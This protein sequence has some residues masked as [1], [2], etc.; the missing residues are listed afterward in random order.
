MRRAPVASVTGHSRSSRPDDVTPADIRQTVGELLRILMLRRWVFFVPFCLATTAAFVSSHYIPR[1]Y[2]ARTTFEQTNDPVSVELPPTLVTSSYT[3]FLTTLE[4]DIKSPEVMYPVLQALGLFDSVPA[5]G[6]SDGG[7]REPAAGRTDP[8]EAMAKKV[9]AQVA[10]SAWR[11]SNYHNVIELS[12]TGPSAEIMTKL[13]NGMKE[14]YKRLVRQRVAERLAGARQ[15]YAQ[16]AD[17]RRR[18]LEKVD[19]EVM[20]IRVRH[21][22]VDPA[23]PDSI[24]LELSSLQAALA[25]QRRAHSRLQ[26]Q[27]ASREEFLANAKAMS[28]ASPSAAEPPVGLSP[29]ALALR[30]SIQD[31]EARIA[32]LKI[33]RGMTELHPEI[34]EERQ[35]L[36]RY[37]QALEAE[38]AA[39][40]QMPAFEGSPLALVGP[41]LEPPSPWTPVVAQ[42]EM[43]LASLVEQR[44][45]TAEE[46]T[47]LEQRVG[48]YVAMQGDV[49]AKRQEFS[50]MEEELARA[51]EDYETYQRLVDQCHQALTVENENR[52]ILFT[53]IVPAEESPIPVSPLAKTVILLSLLAGLVTGAV[54]VIMAELFDRRFRTAAQVTRALG[55]PILECVSE[56]VTAAHRRSG[57][58]RRAVLVPTAAVILAGMV[59]LSGG[60]SFL[61]LNHPESYRKI[62]AVP[63]SAWAQVASLAVKTDA[64]GNDSWSGKGCHGKGC[65]DDFVRSTLRAVPAKSS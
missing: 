5:A 23:N 19:Q 28:S 33:K 7:A 44:D 55:L 47:K 12:Y 37:H 2:E 14:G 22:G 38:L 34:V 4:Q 46:I 58:I 54:F 60:A 11:K 25:E 30:Q 15:W 39:C 18:A 8:R 40:Q 24:A 49:F 62:M 16:Q 21:P 59:L 53:D 10:V 65:Q 42:V 43:D 48:E 31:G 26:S 9:G 52:G 6:E 63:K 29:T 51:R 56:I 57:F 13:L 17:E 61:S 27:I 32:E 20:A 50:R 36:K 45:L 64:P 41:Q 3:Y 1:L 35:F